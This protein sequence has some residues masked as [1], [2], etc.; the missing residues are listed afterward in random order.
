MDSEGEPVQELS[1][2]AM[3]NVTYQIVSIYHKHAF[4]DPDDDQWSR[5]NVHGLN[6]DFLS[7][8]GFPNACELTDN[9][10]E[11]L[12]SFVI[13]CMYANNPVKERK[14]FQK[15]IVHD[16]FLPQWE[17]RMKKSYHKIAI[18][19]KQLNV[20][21]VNVRCANYVHSRFISQFCVT[22]SGKELA[23]R[24]HGFHCS[25]YDCFELYLFYLSKTENL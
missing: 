18:C 5:R 13:L 15:N 25:L 8:C 10:K 2:I 21:I 17:K 24:L 1:A 6:P 20:P 12:E 23:K 19:F 22:S 11:W 4:C 14:L 7:E 9:F 3:D 16:I